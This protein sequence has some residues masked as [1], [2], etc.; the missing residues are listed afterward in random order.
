MVGEEVKF[1]Q[2]GHGGRIGSKCAAGEGADPRLAVVEDLIK[3]AGGGRVERAL[4]AG[5]D[6]VGFGVTAHLA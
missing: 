2:G 3:V 6:L 4:T 5:D 1:G